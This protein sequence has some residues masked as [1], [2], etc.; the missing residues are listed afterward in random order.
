MPP[1]LYLIDGHALAYRTYFAILKS[2]QHL[3]T[4]KGEITTGIYGFTS[5]LLRLLDQEQPEFLAVAFDT[6][7]TF[8]NDL[9]ADY[10]ATRAKMPDDLRPQ[11]DRLHEMVEAFGLPILEKEG[12]EAD[13]V[14]GS[15]AHQAV[16]NGL[17]VKILTGDR[18]LLQ[19]VNERVIVNLA[20]NKLS[21]AKDY[22]PQDVVA[23]LGIYPWQIVDYKALVGD[24]SDNIPGVPGIGEKTA[25]SLLTQYPT[26]DEIYA[27]L[28][29]LPPRLRTLLEKG[30]D[31]AYLSRDL[32]RIRTD[33]PITLDLEQAR[34]SNLDFAAIE[35]FFQELEFRSLI[36]RLKALQ[37]KSPPATTQ[38]PLFGLPL[39]RVGIPNPPETRYHIVST[40][41]ALDEL[42]ERLDRADEFALDTETTSLDPLR[43]ELVGISLAIEPGEGYY[44][45][46]GHTTGEAQLPWALVRERLQP[47]L[48]HP[49]RRKVGHNLKYDLLALAEHGVWVSPLSF[50]TMIAAWLLNPEGYNLNLKGLAE[51]Y[52]GVQ[53]THIEELIGKG[54]KQRSM[55]EVPIE[56]VAAYAAA[57]AEICL[58]LKPLLEERLREVNALRLFNEVEMPLVPVLARMEQAGIALDIP[59]LRQMSRELTQRLAEIEAQIFEVIGYPFNLNS[60]Q[61]LSKALF[62]TLRLEPP[63]RRKRTSSGH[64]ST[65]AEVLEEMRSAHP[66][67]EMILEYR[68][69]SKLKS[70]YVEALPK[71]V[72]PKTGRVHTSFNQTGSVTGRLASSDPNLQNIPARTETGRLVRRAFIAT[73]GMVLISVDYSQIE[74]RIVAHISGDEAMINAFLA[75]QDIHAATAA[76]IYGVPLDQVTKEQRRHAKAINF[77]LIYGMSPY[78]LTRTTDLTLAEAENF[79]R[80]YFHQ[81]PRVKDYIENTRAMATRQGYVETLLGRRRYFPN[82]K[83]PPSPA[84]RQRE[85]REAINAPIQGTAADI[86]KI[87]MV[88]L[89][90]ALETAG[91]SARLLLQVHDELV[92]ECP[93]EEKENTAR[94]VKNVME[95]AYQLVVPLLTEARWGL[96]WGEM[97]PFDDTI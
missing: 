65:S 9:F 56:T 44:I 68:E 24:T 86:M 31:S 85:E 74:L 66:V 16:E 22:G 10:K 42:C 93:E 88:R 49:Q 69:L 76:A 78:G 32:A 61:Q 96:N 11:I 2:G 33:V 26:L 28:D 92:L 63:D 89:P 83:N 13:D 39:A 77:G 29:E 27:H 47:Y 23:L 59:F 20:G 35:R 21:E 17:G 7:R 70:T 72:N 25:V 46:I 45:P 48:N 19:L 82:L 87:A 37:Q 80:A 43:A 90:T 91:L 95:N 41:P 58:R 79:V 54:K 1:T 30:R 15:I 18:D 4:T 71:Q 62:E 81:F 94:V 40:S 14:L 12:Y 55:A 52:L 6:G 60:T 75:G 3:M 34:T 5:V 50:D 38:L 53:M 51:T 97:N 67:I 36:P 84:V 73:P 64:Y 8:R 57:D